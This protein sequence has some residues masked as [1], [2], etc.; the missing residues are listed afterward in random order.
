MRDMAAAQGTANIPSPRLGTIGSIR[1]ERRRN[2]GDGWLSVF[3]AR[4][5]LSVFSARHP[6]LRNL[7][8]FGPA[9]GCVVAGIARAAIAPDDQVTYVGLI[10]FGTLWSAAACVLLCID[11]CDARYRG[12][13]FHYF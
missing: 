10:S 2:S 1:T 4:H 11:E 12:D 5:P 7:L 3:S 13:Q 6:H 9:V 8:Y